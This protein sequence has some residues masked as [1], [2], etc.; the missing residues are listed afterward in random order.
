MSLKVSMQNKSIE[1]IITSIIITV[2]IAAIYVISMLAWTRFDCYMRDK[3]SL[4]YYNR[5]FTQQQCFE[6]LKNEGKWHW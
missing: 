5:H 4:K 6:K 1:I 3:Y 2:M